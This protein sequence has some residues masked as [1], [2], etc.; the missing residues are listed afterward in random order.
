MTKLRCDELRSQREQLKKRIQKP[1]PSAGSPTGLR[2]ACSYIYSLSARDRCTRA[3]ECV[4]LTIN[5]FSELLEESS[6]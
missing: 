2:E 3:F 1:S 6:A 4:L 5:N